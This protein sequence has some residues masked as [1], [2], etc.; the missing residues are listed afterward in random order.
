MVDVKRYWVGK[1]GRVDGDE[2]FVA[3]ERTVSRGDADSAARM[4]AGHVRTHFAAADAVVDGTREIE[5][6]VDH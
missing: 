4:S 5:Q 6:V 3:G 1:S 2:D